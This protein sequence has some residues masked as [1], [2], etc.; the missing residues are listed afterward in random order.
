MK[1]LV[2]TSQTQGIRP[3][4]FTH[5]VEGELVTVSLVCRRDQLDPANGSCGCGRAFSG[6]NSHRATT[7]AMVKWVDLSQEDYIEALRSSLLQGG[8][9]DDDVE[10]LAAS[11][12][13]LADTLC[14]GTVLGR[15]G[16]D[17]MIRRL[18]DAAAADVWQPA[19]PP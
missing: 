19:T 16:D 14:E 6:L 7:T 9:A 12:A 4:D 3:G 18:P 8:W 2:A 13:E 5:C 11:L 17:I 10:D 1:V 15:L